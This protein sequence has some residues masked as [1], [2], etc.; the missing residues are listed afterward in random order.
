MSQPRTPF[1]WRSATYHVHE[2]R[3][4]IEPRVGPRVTVPGLVGDRAAGVDQGAEVARAK[5]LAV[6]AAQ[7]EVE[8]FI[9][10]GA[11]DAQRVRSRPVADVLRLYALRVGR[12][13]R[14]AVVHRTA[15]RA[16]DQ[17]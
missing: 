1:Q 17:V 15:H 6:A 7:R 11:G 10:G 9:P 13:P 3:V 12:P 2:D 14:V 4:R 5:A 16:P 8:V